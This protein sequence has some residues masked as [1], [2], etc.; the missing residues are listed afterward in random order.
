VVGCICFLPFPSWQSLVGLITSASVLMYAGAPLSL[1]VFRKRLPNA[2]RPYRLPAAGV[3]SP[4]AFI[5]SGLIILWSG[6]DT[7]WKLGVAILIGYL[8]LALTRVFRLNTHNPLMQWRA[9]QWLP[10]YL[11][12]LGVIVY[13]SPYGPMK[14]PVIP[15]WWDILAIAV[16]SLV[17][18]YW[19]LAVA[20]PTEQIEH[21]V[22]DVVAPENEGLPDM[23]VA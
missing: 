23:P 19:A 6:W 18:Y 2:D 20:L 13:L 14:N 3:L 17:V 7:D 11:V 4:L 21:M 16:F 1:G 22:D 12:G 15:L 5:V 9:A 10:V 8:I